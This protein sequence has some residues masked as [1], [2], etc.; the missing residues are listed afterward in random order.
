MQDTPRIP[1]Q[2]SLWKLDVATYTAHSLHGPNRN[3]VESNCYIDIWVELIHAA[4]LEVYPFLAFTLASDFENDQWTFYK[5]SFEDIQSLYGISVHE[6][7]LW[8]G[9]HQQIAR[10]LQHNKMVLLE[11]DAFFL[12]DTQETDYKQNHVKTTIGIESIDL[13]NKTM[14]YFHNAGYFQL[15]EDDFNSIFHLNKPAIDGYLP[16]YCEIAKLDNLHK[17]SPEII[18]DKAKE[19]LNHY[20]AQLPKNNPITRFKEGFAQELVYLCEQ[21]L[22]S[23]H[24]YAFGSLRQLGSGYEFTAYFLRAL[25]EA[26]GHD[27]L[28][29]IA[30]M[31]DEISVT[32]KTLILKG[33]RM[34]NRKNIKDVSA[35]FDSMAQHWDNA[36]AA[37]KE[38]LA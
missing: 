10:Q 15:K 3:F 36:M 1:A 20:L 25:Q 27:R 5:P 13:E 9:L 21:G 32:A 28:E 22:E 16:P 8:G 17:Y 31:F 38:Q 37:L 2:A 29:S 23:Y 6:L 12:P 7:Y 33:A 18:R 24:H 19:R 11:A 4:G 30:A 14:G 35:D 26:E 34:V